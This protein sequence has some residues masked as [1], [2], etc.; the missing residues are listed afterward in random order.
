MKNEE[1]VA[2]GVPGTARPSGVVPGALHGDSLIAIGSYAGQLAVQA[3][4]P[5][6]A[7]SSLLWYSP[8]GNAITPLLGGAAAGGGTVSAAFLFGQPADGA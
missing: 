2:S 8:A 6:H 4:T 3:E 7:G 1:D 5:C